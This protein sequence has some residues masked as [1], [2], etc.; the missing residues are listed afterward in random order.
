MEAAW[1][2][3]GFIKRAKKKCDK[4][5]E[6]RKEEVEVGPTANTNL[7]GKNINSDINVTYKCEAFI[8]ACMSL[9]H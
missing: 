8:Y 7:T 3:T 6:E 2:R 9:L 4:R 1:G 5:Q